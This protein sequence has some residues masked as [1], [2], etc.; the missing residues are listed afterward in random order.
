ME[1]ICFL[2]SVIR[3][4]WLL[5]VGTGIYSIINKRDASV[6]TEVKVTGI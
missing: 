1:Q 2:I 4:F 6:H 5:Q 3:I